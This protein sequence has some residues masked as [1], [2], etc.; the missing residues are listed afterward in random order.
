MKRVCSSCG[1]P[2]EALKGVCGYCN[3]H[4]TNATST[5]YPAFLVEFRKRQTDMAGRNAVLDH[6]VG[7]AF[8]VE[9][10]HISELFL[11]E[12]L[13]NLTLLCLSLKSSARQNSDV[14]VSDLQM[15]RAKVAKAWIYKL[16]EAV[17]KLRLIGADDANSLV[18]CESLD[19]AIAESLKTL[20][21]QQMKV[22]LIGISAGL[23]LVLITGISF[24]LS[25]LGY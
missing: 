19:R 4:L 1:A 15:G 13:E 8:A 20:K 22:P 24:W 7:R 9:T 6:L 17:D 21:R 3:A 23:I 18:L 25:S 16:E 10:A 14:S 12:D 5:D 11:P 2:A